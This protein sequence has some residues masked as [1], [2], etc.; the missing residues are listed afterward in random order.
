MFSILWDEVTRFAKEVA[1]VAVFGYPLETGIQRYLEYING[2]Y[3]QHPRLEEWCK[4]V[5]V[6]K[7]I[8]RAATAP[9]DL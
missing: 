8:I 3:S 7:A 2:E 9:E 4:R 1:V 6:Q 5:M